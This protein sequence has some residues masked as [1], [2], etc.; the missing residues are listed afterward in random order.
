MNLETLSLFCALEERLHSVSPDLGN[1]NHPLWEHVTWYPAVLYLMS[2]WRCP[3]RARLYDGSL[4]TACFTSALFNN[5]YWR[6]THILMVDQ[7]HHVSNRVSLPKA[8][9]RISI[10]ICGPKGVFTVTFE[11]AILYTN[12]FL[13]ASA[14]YCQ[15]D[16]S[17]QL[18]NGWYLLLSVIVCIGHQGTFSSWIL[19]CGSIYCRW[20]RLFW[21]AAFQMK[22]PEHII[23]SV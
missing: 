18:D 7:V 3:I 2:H 6:A 13:L 10:F 20:A 14:A 1:W 17:F 23:P 4:E 15:Y 5:S 9:P 19:T 11:I 21:V 22:W 8:S 16:N 12:H